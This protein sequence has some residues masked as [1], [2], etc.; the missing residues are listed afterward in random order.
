MHKKALT[1][2]SLA[3]KEDNKWRFHDGSAVISGCI[4]DEAF[5]RRIDNNLIA[6]AKGDILICE[7]RTKQTQDLNVLKTEYFIEQVVEHKPA[8]R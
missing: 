5:L 7:V 4:L 1:I 3:F 6:F 2:I 8:V